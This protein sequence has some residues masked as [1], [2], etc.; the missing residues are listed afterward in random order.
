MISVDGFVLRFMFSRKQE[1]SLTAAL[2]YSI[3]VGYFCQLRT[4]R[5]FRARIL[6]C[7]V[8][9]IPLSRRWYSI[10]S[11]AWPRYLYVNRCLRAQVITS[12]YTTSSSMNWDTVL[13]VHRKLRRCMLSRVL[14]VKLG[15]AVS[16]EHSQ[17]I[18]A[19]ASWLAQ[20]ECIVS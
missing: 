8:S 12:P 10:M 18:V 19:T 9:N 20:V 1:G 11:T 3:G 7:S 15:E 16:R 17:L 14:R 6:R 2:T 4:R 5:T 13:G